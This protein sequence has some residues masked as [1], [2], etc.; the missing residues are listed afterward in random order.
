MTKIG[1]N[2]NEAE[3][4]TTSVSSAMVLRKLENAILSGYFK[5]R[6]R[7]VERDLLA[8]F[9]VSRTVIREVLKMLEAKGLVKITPFRG[10]I[11]VDLTAKEVEE[12]FFLRLRLEAIAA[13]LVIRNITQIEIQQLKK[14]CRELDR[15]LRE[16]TDQMIEKDNEFH[17]ALFQP[18]RNSHLNDMIDYLSTKA[19]MVKFNAWSLPKRIEQSRLEHKSMMEALERRDG[20]AFEKLVIDHLLFSK[21]SYVAQLTRIDAKLTTTG[22]SGSKRRQD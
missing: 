2:T 12:I 17:R 16:G 19:H 14:L 18:S 21:N 1:T 13:A 20:A 11:V 9:D 6:E 8:H 22:L 7:L 4:S 3:N 10:A 5:P 15:H